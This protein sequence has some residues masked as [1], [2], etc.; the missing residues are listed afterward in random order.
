[1]IKF[2]W[3]HKKHGMLSAKGFACRQDGTLLLRDSGVKTF[4]FYGIMWGLNFF[5]YISKDA[6]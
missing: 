1:M 3:G 5:G 4:R 6:K 2:Y